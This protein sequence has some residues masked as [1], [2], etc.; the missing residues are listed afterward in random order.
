MTV[1]NAKIR[2]CARH[3]Q[4]FD[5]ILA[6]R[7]F[8]CGENIA[9]ADI[10]AGTSLYRYFRIDIERPSVPNV[11]GWYRRLQDRPAYRE[12]I[13]VPFGELYGRLDY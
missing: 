13:M 1:V 12:H 10:P 9:L 6:N 11:E 2:T 5:G 8:L 7:P 4:L 3:F